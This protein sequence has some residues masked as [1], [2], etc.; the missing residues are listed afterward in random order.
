MLT[1]NLNLW[2]VFSVSAEYH[3]SLWGAKDKRMGAFIQ[4]D[5]YA[6][7]QMN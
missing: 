4:D 5:E 1:M 6:Y 7:S 2:I 3:G